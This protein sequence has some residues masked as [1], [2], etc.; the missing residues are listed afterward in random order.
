MLIRYLHFLILLLLVRDSSAKSVQGILRGSI[1]QFGHFEE[2]LT[3]KAPF[4]TQYCLATITANVPATKNPRDSK[5][6]WYEGNETVIN[7]I[8]VSK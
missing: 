5:S 6:L 8:Y 1:A 4:P 3:A 2:C 7:K